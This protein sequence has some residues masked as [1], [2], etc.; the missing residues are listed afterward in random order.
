M[1]ASTPL[2]SKPRSTGARDGGW[3]DLHTHTIVSDGTLSPAELVQRARE[4]GLGALAITDHDTL[5]GLLEACRASETLGM[6]VIPGVEISVDGE[7]GRSFHLLAYG[8]S[9]SN[10][11]L[12]AFLEGLQKRRECR[13][14]QVLEK[15]AKLGFPLERP[16]GQ[17]GIPGAQLGRP[18]IAMALVR[19]GY[20][21]SIEEAFS[22]FLAKG[23]PAY[24]PRQRPKYSEAIGEVLAAGCV[25]VL[26]HPHSIGLQG[27]RELEAFVGKLVEAGLMGIEAI[28]PEGGPAMKEHCEAMSRKWKLILTGG[29]DFH[30][31]IKPHIQLGWGRGTLRVPFSWAESLAEAVERV[32]PRA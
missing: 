1:V 7:E 20:V 6:W 13:N 11:R 19:R 25:P 3:A 18:H 28:F 29:T 27:F 26:A 21:G 2:G 15:L 24:V 30:G 5:E 4:I 10:P 22:R 16:M 14:L 8:A 32:R 17:F 23:A 31:D 9:A 12:A